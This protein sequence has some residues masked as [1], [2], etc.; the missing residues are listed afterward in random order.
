MLRAAMERMGVHTHLSRRT[1]AV[2]GDA[3][4][5]GLMFDD[6][7]RLECDMVV[8]SAGIRPERRAGEG[9]RP[10]GRAR[11]RRWRRSAVG[12]RPARLRHRR[13]RAASRPGLRARRAAVGTGAGA[14]RSPDRQQRA[15]RVSRLSGV[16]EVEGDGRR[17]GGDGRQGASRRRRGRALLRAVARRLQEDGRAGRPAGRR[18]PARRPRRGAV[19]AAGLRSRPCR[20]PTTAPS[21]CFRR[22]AAI[23]R[24]RRR[25]CPTTRRSATATASPRAG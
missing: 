11:H 8:V 21:C 9:R 4:S 16:H 6:G 3:Q 22:C 19:A 18:H 10:G 20:C 23:H 7:S 2:L 17:S 1:T 12:E 5:P 14:R 24:C 13:M 15:R 25:S